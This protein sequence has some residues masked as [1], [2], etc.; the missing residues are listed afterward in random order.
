MNESS[1]ITAQPRS[2]LTATEHTIAE[3]WNEVLRNSAPLQ[4]SDNFFAVGGDSMAMV[5]LEFRIQ[6]QMGVAL[7]PGTVLA[8]PTLRELSS[9][10]DSLISP[11]I[12]AR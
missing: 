2:E 8:A 1:S 9:T 4:P 11:V 6:E 5:T 7:A 12:E 10:V 3:L